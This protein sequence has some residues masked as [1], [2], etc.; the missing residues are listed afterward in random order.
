MI[1]HIFIPV[2]APAWVLDFTRRCVEAL[3]NYLRDNIIDVTWAE[4]K[5]EDNERQES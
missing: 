3:V 2:D 4:L 1:F 5:G